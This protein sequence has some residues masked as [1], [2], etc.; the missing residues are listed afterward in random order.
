MNTRALLLSSL[1]LT[2]TTCQKM[3]KAG[4]PETSAGE[5]ISQIDSQPPTRAQLVNLNNQGVIYINRGEFSA[6]IEKLREALQLDPYYEKARENLMLAY[7]GKAT[8]QK[9][10]REKIRY[11]LISVLLRPQNEDTL[12]KL[13]DVLKEMHQDPQDASTYERIGREKLVE[14]D[15][16]AAFAAYSLSLNHKDTG[17]VREILHKI[18]CTIKEQNL[19]YYLPRAT[20][21][22]LKP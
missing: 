21:E 13:G 3:A 19:S 18:Q 10:N 15:T 11:L 4:A 9:D 20:A 2:L 6:A 16:L 14:K 7:K 8:A 22:I 12:Q 17:E 1:I 5:N